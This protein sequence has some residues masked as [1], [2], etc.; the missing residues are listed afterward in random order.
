M[1][2]TVDPFTYAANL[3]YPEGG[4]RVNKYVPHVPH[5]PQREFLKLDCL[6]A[7]YGGAAGGG[8][9]DA[10]LMA[11]LQY[12]DVPNYSAIL[13][14]R[15]SPDL[16][17][18]DGLVPRSK[19]WLFPV[20]GHSAWNG[21]RMVW[22]FP[23]GATLRFGHA[24]Y[25]DDVLKFQGH[26]YQF[27]GFDELTHFTE[28]Q[29][30]YL[31]SR[32]RKLSTGTGAVVPLR[33]RGASN[34]GGPGHDWVKKRFVTKERDL[35]DPADT[36]E[37]VNARTFVPARLAD[38]PSI[39][40]E[41][42]RASLAALEPEERAQL[43]DGDWDARMP[44]DWYFH[45]L[46]AVQALGAQ[47]EELLTANQSLGDNV[48]SLRFRHGAGKMPP[49]VGGRLQLGIDW[50]QSTHAVLGWPLE[51]GGFF[52]AREYV[53]YG[54]EPGEKTHKM[55][56]LNEWGLP[57][58]RAFFD[59]AGVQSQKTFNATAEAKLGNARPAAKAVPFGAQAPRTARTA[60][61]S[62]KG[63]GCAYVR[64]LARNAADGRATQVLAISPKCPVLLSQMRYLQNDPEDPVGAWLK[65]E[66]QHGPDAL[67][68]LV[69]TTAL[70]HRL[71]I[72][73]QAVG[74]RG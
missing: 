61:K 74:A 44:G 62:Y 19:E 14:R 35:L 25:E 42:Y 73:N 4:A 65:D 55:L 15:V 30:R 58:D 54:E 50:G 41:S 31:F 27:I 36:E 64:R 32:L 34:P 67:V 52:V 37:V 12:V 59:A 13:F 40:Q 71:M 48:V 47:Y 69:T 16:H 7:L 56:R 20:I 2:E 66:N 43:L 21:E 68:A 45:D 8:K 18:A 9:S 28:R 70:R 17:G 51:D 5:P 39:D 57:W 6:E 3:L 26:A 60:L 1:S 23:S 49:P 46:S 10:L 53:S 63:V 38:N 24:Q 29:Y 11:A 33:M 72:E 22:T